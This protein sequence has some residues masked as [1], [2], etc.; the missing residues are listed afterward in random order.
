[1]EKKEL[2]LCN[3]KRHC[4]VSEDCG[5]NCKHTSEIEYAL[6][7]KDEM[8]FDEYSDSRWEKEEDDA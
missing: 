2:Y 3:Q 5:K 7:N 8:I 6:H 1:M 4:N